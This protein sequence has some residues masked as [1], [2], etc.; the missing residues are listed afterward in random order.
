MGGEGGDEGQKA[1]EADKEEQRGSRRIKRQRATATASRAGRDRAHTSTGSAGGGCVAAA[2]HA[3]LAGPADHFRRGAGTARPL[4]HLLL[5]A[6][7][8]V[9]RGGAAAAAAILALLITTVL[10]RVQFP[11]ASRGPP[12]TKAELA[13]T[14]QQAA[15]AL[16]EHQHT[17]LRQ[18]QRWSD[19]DHPPPDTPPPHARRRPERRDEAG[20]SWQELHSSMVAYYPFAIGFEADAAANR[21]SSVRWLP[22]RRRWGLQ[23]GLPWRSKGLTWCCAI[24]AQPAARSLR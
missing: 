3:V 19:A 14:Y 15:A 22:G 6:V 8:P 5:G 17:A 10:Q 2:L 4:C 20:L 23:T 24:C 11:R 7:V 16:L 21:R 18:I 12:P 13:Q 1:E 9:G